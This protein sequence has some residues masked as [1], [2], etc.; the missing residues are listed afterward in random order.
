MSL[1][2]A[3][4]LQVLPIRVPP[5]YGATATTPPIS[6]IIFV[7]PAAVAPLA[8]AHAI[9][10]WRWYV[11]SS[12]LFFLSARHSVSLLKMQTVCLENYK[13]IPVSFL[14]IE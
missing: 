10:V 8:R 3:V 13:L 7:R 5:A 1:I 11:A 2:Q 6:L 4:V 14:R 9:S 12:S